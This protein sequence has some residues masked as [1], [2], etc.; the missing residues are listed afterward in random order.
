MKSFLDKMKS[1][2][3]FNIRVFVTESNESS[4]KEEV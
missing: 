4:H 2:N 3:A 1:T